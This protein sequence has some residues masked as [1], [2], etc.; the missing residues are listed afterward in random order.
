MKLIYALLLVSTAAISQTTAPLQ[1]ATVNDLIDK[2]S[3][4]DDQAKTR[5]LGGRNLAPASKSIDLVIQFDSNSAKLKEPSKPLLDNLAEAM[6][7]ERLSAIRFKVE[8]HTDAQGTAQQNLRLSLNR[9]ETVS[10]YL[11]DRGVAKDRLS[12]EGK[13][14]SELLMP[15]KPR[16]A[17]NRRVRITTQP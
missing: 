3:P 12:V 6:T 14:F 1:S 8:G 4:A 10:A 15:D 2:L 16:A 11:A 13:G 17:E 9:A 7:N 5:S